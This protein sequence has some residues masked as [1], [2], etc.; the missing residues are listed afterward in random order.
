MV[1]ESLQQALAREMKEE[2]GLLSDCVDVHSGEVL[3][4]VFNPI[5]DERK[6]NSKDKR[7]KV[8]IFVGVRVSG[9]V[10]I[11]LNSENADCVIADN[12]SQLKKFMRGARYHKYEGTLS[13]IAHARGRGLLA[14][15][16]GK[17]MLQAAA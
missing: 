7:D 11:G 17:S 4:V 16:W 12:I 6:A 14:S 15:H 10:S 1:G 3:N 13:A 2:L 8:L 9:L 5:P